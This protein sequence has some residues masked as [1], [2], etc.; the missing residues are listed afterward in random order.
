[1][2]RNLGP[3]Q[4]QEPTKYELTMRVKDDDGQWQDY[5]LRLLE[6]KSAREINEEFTGQ[7]AVA[8][9]VIC[10]NDCYLCGTDDLKKRMIAKGGKAVTFAEATALLERA[11]P[12]VLGRVVPKILPDNVTRVFDCPVVKLEE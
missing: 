4:E 5:N 6:G 12:D 7:Q 9:I 11:A 1:M 3:K 10:G 2:S 8:K